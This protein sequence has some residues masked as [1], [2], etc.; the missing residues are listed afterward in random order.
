[1]GAVLALGYIASRAIFDYARG[2]NLVSRGTRVMGSVGGIMQNPNDLAM[3]M[4]VFL[5]FAALLAMQPGSLFKRLVAAGCGAAM[6]GAIVASGSRGRIPGVRGDDAVLAAFSVRKRPGS[7]SPGRRGDLRDARGTRLVLAAVCQHHGREQGRR[8]VV[9]GAQA[10]HGRVLGRLPAESDHRRRGRA[11]QGLEPAGARGLA[12]GAQRVAA[13]RRRARRLRLRAFLFLV[14]R[15]FYAVFQTR[16]LLPS[17]PRGGRGA[18]A[19]DPVE[20]QFLD[21]HSAAMA[22]SLAGWFVVRVLRSIAYNW[23]FYYLLALAAAPRDILSARSAPVP[24]RGRG[25]RPRVAAR[26]PRCDGKARA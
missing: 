26:R 23:T 5:P 4:V 7:C 22:A 21:A 25:A 6:I 16:R 1:V 3:N 19:A 8:A 12:R 10:P 17:A 20:A 24:R 13:G 14:C 2:V 15:A 9:A 18:G 11:V